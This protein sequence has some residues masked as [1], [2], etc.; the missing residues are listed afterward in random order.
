MD[1]FNISKERATLGCPEASVAKSKYLLILNHYLRVC[2]QCLLHWLW[3]HRLFSKRQTPKYHNL[4][5]VIKTQVRWC[6][7]SDD[8]SPLIKFLIVKPGRLCEDVLLCGAI[9]DQKQTEHEPDGFSTG[10]QTRYS[11]EQKTWSS[12][13]KYR[14]TW[15][16]PQQRSI[17]Q[18]VTRKKVSEFPRATM[19]LIPSD[20]STKQY[21]NE[22]IRYMHKL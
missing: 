9:S 14:R 13:R 4:I 21:E 17:R 19:A 10:G 7:E 1:G 18:Y 5:E 12:F 22:E 2:T 16:I 20:I 6:S 8:H 3:M 15:R 11:K